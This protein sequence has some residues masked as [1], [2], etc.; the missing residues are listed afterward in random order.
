MDFSSQQYLKDKVGIL[1]W[2]LPAFL[3]N[4]PSSSACVPVRGRSTISIVTTSDSASSLIH[5]TRPGKQCTSFLF[6]TII[7]FHPHTLQ[8]V[9]KTVLTLGRNY[10][11]DTVFPPCGRGKSHIMWT[12]GKLCPPVLCRMLALAEMI[13]KWNTQRLRGAL[14][15]DTNIKTQITQ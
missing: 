5:M 13:K 2:H 11:R 12:L 10:G 6:H 15:P 3:P 1:G 9:C 8:Q 7:H 14:W 4:S